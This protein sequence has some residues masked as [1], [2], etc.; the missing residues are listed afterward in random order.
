VGIF[1]VL[2]MRRK[3]RKHPV[4]ARRSVRRTRPSASKS[5]RNR[6]HLFPP[7]SE[8][9]PSVLQRWVYFFLCGLFG[10]CP[11]GEEPRVLLEGLFGTVGAQNVPSPVDINNG[12][13]GRLDSAQSWRLIFEFWHRKTGC[14]TVNLTVWGQN[15]FRSEKEKGV[16]NP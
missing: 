8:T 6:P 2:C 14:Q 12:G 3:K 4:C 11:F 13:V 1:G 10:V 15:E 16:A 9:L 5:H 7:T